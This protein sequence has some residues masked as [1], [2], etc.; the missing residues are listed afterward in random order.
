M[1]KKLTKNLIKYMVGAAILAVFILVVSMLYQARKSVYKNADEKIL[2]VKDKILAN[3]EEIARLTKNVGEENLVK[4]RFFAELIKRDPE[5]IED[6]AKLSELCDRMKTSEINIVDEKGI[7]THSTESAYVNFDMASGEQSAAFL[8]ILDDPSCELVQEPQ[9][10]AALGEVMQYIGVTRLDTKGII[11]IG[12][13]P[14]VLN[15]ALAETA[16]DKVLKE[17][18]FGSD[19]YVFA[20][21]KDDYTVV[22]DRDSSVIGK[23]AVEVG[24]N[25]NMQEG[26]SAY[27]HVQHSVF[28]YKASICDKYIVGVVLP[29]KELYMSA[30]GT[31]V[32][33]TVCIVLI[34]IIILVLINSFINKNIVSVLMRLSSAVDKISSGDYSIVVD[35][36]SAPEFE[37][38]SVGINKMVENINENMAQN[39]SLLKAQKEDME[40]SML[41]IKN[42]KSVCGV[43]E[44]TSKETLENSM[45]IT[46]GNEEQKNV[47]DD[48]RSTME[49]LS[50]KLRESAS[51]ATDISDD[52]L[53][54]VEDLLQTRDQVN[55]LSDS[56][57]EITATS[58]EIEKII[59][60]IDEIAQQTN[61]LSL[62]ASI[63][64]ARA[65]ELGKGFAVVATEIGQLANRTT[66]AAR[67]TGTLIKNSIDAVRN[68]REITTQ[69]VEGFGGAVDK[70]Q[71]ASQEVRGISEIVSSHVSLIENASQGLNRIA[72]VVESNRELAANCEKTAQNMADEAEKLYDM[73]EQ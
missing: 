7:I 61:M 4:A 20:I 35:E 65:G 2:S 57:S 41:L 17:F 31:S 48:M 72:D 6:T 53:T 59:D 40:S 38:L 22:A 45:L 14:A 33:V 23:D 32:L 39:E 8:K 58:E 24:Y 51:S 30:L 49:D 28:W 13:K 71:H 3:D 64:A 69:A 21:N 52:T 1:G 46:Q 60:E 27:C 11:Q 36:V 47:I 5:I 62:N 29:I 15:E 63:E 56:M 25:A 54:A 67:E 44:D 9:A 19:G 42:V 34:N 73:V 10:N 68:G 43:I 66:E 70:I 26:E 55:R 18:D 50:S 16:I 12:I 37:V